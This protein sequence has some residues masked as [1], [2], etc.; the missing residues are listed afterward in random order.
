[1]NGRKTR[2]ERFEDL[3][4]NPQHG[5]RHRNLLKLARLGRL[6]SV[7]NSELTQLIHAHWDGTDPLTEREVEDAVAKVEREIP[8]GG[9]IPEGVKL[10]DEER[11]R[12]RSKLPP[13]PP[14][15][16]PATYGEATFF[17]RMAAAGRAW[18]E[19]RPIYGGRRS[20]ALYDLSPVQFPPTGW[21]EQAALMI[22]RLATDWL[23]FTFAG[24]Q[25]S[26]RDGHHLNQAERLAWDIREGKVEIPPQIIA[27]Q[28]TGS[29]S[30]IADKSPAGGHWSMATKR[31]ILH[32]RHAVI[33]FDGDGE[34]PLPL[35]TQADFWLGCITQHTLAP[36]ALTFSGS[37]SI[38]GIVRLLEL[39]D[40]DELAAPH[41]EGGTLL[42]HYAKLAKCGAEELTA[43]ALWAAQWRDLERLLG[44]APDKLYHLDGACKD[45]T[46]Q[47]RLAGHLRR[48]KRRRQTLLWLAEPDLRDLPRVDE[49]PV[50]A[51]LE[52]EEQNKE[53][54]Q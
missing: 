43:A 10:A 4:H 48:D 9:D 14:A 26:P 39:R 25:T 53:A 27:N 8:L 36:V 34:H 42:E 23:G 33:E 30:W 31:E 37:K 11:R 19:D 24:E 50:E 49:E 13:P 18:V 17:E 45:A 21:R 6:A 15:P 46:R 41:P 22:D 29:R 38:H 16:A 1:M 47:T 28:L 35:G 12:F 5:S 3:L 44:S 20:A 40:R 51:C 54:T 2:L 7:E 32:Y 52:L